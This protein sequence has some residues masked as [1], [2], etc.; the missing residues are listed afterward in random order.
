MPKDT[1]EKKE[2][3]QWARPCE[4]PPPQDPNLPSDSDESASDNCWVHHPMSGEVLGKRGFWKVMRKGA[5]GGALVNV[6]LCRD[7]LFVNV[8][9]AT[10]RLHL[11]GQCSTVM[12]NIVSLLPVAL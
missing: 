11:T 6:P 12:S 3:S 1:D 10:S 4:A 7:D 8:F 2:H 5:N 9:S